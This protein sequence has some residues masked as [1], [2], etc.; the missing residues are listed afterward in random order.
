[1]TGD[2]GAL[3]IA[4][5]TCSD[6][7][8]AERIGRAL[9]SERLAACVNL[10]PSLR[11]FYWWQGRVDE[12]VEIILIAKTSTAHAEALVARVRALH[13]YTVP[14]VVLVP[15]D[16]GNADYLTWLSGELAPT[17]PTRSITPAPPG[18][19]TSAPPPG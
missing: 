2:P 3:R 10:L 7:S 1:M 16:G 9:V 12:A 13:S 18:A 6:V 15:V 4:Y 8:E 11:S 14:C 5:V 17:I 19:T